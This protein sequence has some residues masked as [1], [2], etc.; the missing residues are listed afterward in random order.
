MNPKR[1]HIIAFN[2]PWPA[3]YGGAIDIFYKL[4]A[5]SEVGIS[6]VLHCFQYGRNKAPELEK[7]CEKV[8]YYKRSTGISSQL[9]C[10]PYIVFSRRNNSL[11]NNLLLDN[12]P[13]LFEGLHC[14]YFLDCLQLKNRLK[15]VR[16]HNVEHLYY[17]GLALN[18]DSIFLKMYFNCEAEKL[19]RY[20]QILHKADYILP[21][22]TAD[23][24]YFE[25]KFGKEKVV[26][27]P[28]FFE[29]TEWRLQNR[30]PEK[31]YPFV[32]YHGD[33]ST[34][35]NHHAACFLI[36]SVAGNDESVKWVF[37]GKNPDVKL[38]KLAESRKNISILANLNDQ[39]MEN[40]IQRAT[41]HILFTAQVSGVKVKLIHALHSGGHCL[42][43]RAMVE[44]SGLEELCEIIPDKPEDIF[45]EVK[46][47][48][49]IRLSKQEIDKRMLTFDEIYNNSKNALIIKS[50][51]FK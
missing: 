27:T 29:N 36:E 9:S 35:E 37:A 6:I 34:A 51:L 16:A 14:C 25:K 44:G 26:L 3:D 2:V 48:I 18:T 24:I 46:K 4:K 11:L 23:L 49:S 5:L 17:K 43:N 20:E 19:K 41:V 12:A 39:E 22:S 15:I 1:L 30:A 33:L 31:N 40:L 7:Y 42:A 28:L 38:L 47:F 8:Y 45:L 13:I 21:L 50:F 10:L 32:L